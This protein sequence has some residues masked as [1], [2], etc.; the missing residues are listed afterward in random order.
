MRVSATPMGPTEVLS[1]CEQGPGQPRYGTV[2][3]SIVLPV[4]VVE[5][6]AAAA[7]VVVD[8]PGGSVQ[9]VGQ[10]VTPLRLKAVPP[11]SNSSSDTT[12]AEWAKCS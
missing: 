9:G 4:G 3:S 10:Y 6:D 7:V 11:R 12:N 8:P 2:I 5:V 1:G